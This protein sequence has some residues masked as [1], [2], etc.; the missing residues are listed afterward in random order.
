VI[1]K[2]SKT[3]EIKIGVPPVSS[4]IKKE[5]G[6]EKAKTAQAEKAGEEK[7]I[8]KESAKAG[9]EKVEKEEATEEGE[10][11]AAEEGE[12]AETEEGV[13]EGVAKKEGEEVIGNLTMKQVVKIAKMKMDDL[14]A[15]DLKAAVKQVVGTANSMMGIRIEGKKP[16]DVIVDI[17]KGKY[18]SL[19]KE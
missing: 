10:A 16:K 9:E 19:L 6:I 3:F 14:L 8:T 4:L 13:E 11:E 2:E 12:S 1:D 7:K 5:L 17:E 18:D 15:K